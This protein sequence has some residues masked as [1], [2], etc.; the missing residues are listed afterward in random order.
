MYAILAKNFKTKHKATPKIIYILLYHNDKKATEP[1]EKIYALFGHL[2]YE[3]LHQ[4]TVA[5][6][7]TF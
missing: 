4:A 7:I 5:K 2:K 1:G 3:R 6:I